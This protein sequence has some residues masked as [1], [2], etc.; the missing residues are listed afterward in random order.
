MC[1]TLDREIVARRSGSWPGVT[2]GDHRYGGTEWRVESR[3]I[4]HAHAWGMLDVAYLRALCDTLIEEGLTGV[5]HLLDRF[6]RAAVCIESPDNCEHARWLVRLS[7]LHRV[8]VLKEAPAG[9]EGYAAIDAAAEL[10]A[11]DPSE[12][13]RASVDRRGPEQVSTPDE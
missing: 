8:N 4:R 10:D 3:E 9:A 6:G 11:L 7:Y 13:I 5:H 2:V 12:P 1:P